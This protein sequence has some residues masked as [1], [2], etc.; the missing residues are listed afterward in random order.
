MAI[1]NFTESDTEKRHRKARVQYANDLLRKS[2]LLQ[3]RA[4]KEREKALLIKHQCSM[5]G[6]IKKKIVEFFRG[7][8]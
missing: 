4:E 6:R 3:E 5:V 7:N 8:L 1:T 2:E